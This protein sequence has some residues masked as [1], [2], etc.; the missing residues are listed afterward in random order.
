MAQAVPYSPYIAPGKA[1]AEFL[2]FGPEALGRLTDDE[3][4]VLAGENA[5]L[6]AYDMLDFALIWKV[7]QDDLPRCRTLDTS[8]TERP[9]WPQNTRKAREPPS[10][11][12]FAAQPA[13]ESG[14]AFG[15]PTCPCTLRKKE[16]ADVKKATLAMALVAGFALAA[17]RISVSIGLVRLR[18]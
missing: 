4:R 15:A 11:V 18:R 10:S 7:Y 2:R 12:R 9:A 17:P 13:I 3:Q 14:I 8:V 6:V 1:G 5:P 16:Q